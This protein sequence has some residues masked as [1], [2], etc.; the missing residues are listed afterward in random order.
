MPTTV[1]TT[2]YGAA[3]YN[4]LRRAV[5]EAKAGDPLQLVTVVVPSE[6]IGVAARRA[7]AR[8]DH[9]H[10]AGIAAISIMTL[11]RVAETRSARALLAEGRRPLTGP[12]L[13]DAVR[14]RLT[15]DPGPFE[16]VADHIGTVR[17]LADA[18]RTLKPYRDDVLDALGD[19]EVVAATVAVHRAL[20]ADL[21]TSTYDET[22]LLRRAAEHGGGDEP[23]VVLLPQDLDPPE[24]AL[25]E[26][27]ST[28]VDLRILLGITGHDDADAGPLAVARA[29][30]HDVHPDGEA[31]PTA[32]RVLHAS[33]PDDEVRA[34]VRRV[35][36]DLATHKGHRIAVLHASSDPYARLLH[37]HLARADI[38]FFGRGIRPAVESAYGR[39]VMRLL[40]LP[41]HD[42]ART[43]VLAVVA[44]GPVR[45]GDRH[46][47]S[48]AWE[49]V[50]RAA[51][52][53]R[54]AAWSRLETFARHTRAKAANERQ[55]EGARDWL[56]ARHERDSETADDLRAFVEGLQ[57]SLAAIDAAT[58]WADATSAVRRL[59]ELLADD[60]PPEDATAARRVDATLTAAATGTTPPSRRRVVELLE[61][62]LDAVLDRVGTIGIGV[63][64]GP[65][66]EGVGDDVDRVYI[67]GAAEGLLPPR[68]A[69][70]PLLPDR[71]RERT[72]GAL[73]TTR[74][75]TARQHRHV[76]AA[77]AAAPREGRTMSFPRGDLRRGGERVPSRWL[78][79]TLRVLGRDRGLQ[80]TKWRE[81][82]RRLESSSSYPAA[83]LAAH[84][85]ASAQ[86][87]RQV[88]A[89]AGTLEGD[90]TI[91]RAHRLRR[92]R[93]SDQFT[94]YD[95]NLVGE[96][97]P[98]PTASDRLSP[99]ALEEWVRCPHAYF[100]FRLLGV[101]P[102]E[103]PEE[104][105]QISAMERGFVLHDVWDKLV[106]AA[107]D[108]GWAP[109]PGEPWPPRA[110][111]RIE[112]LAESAFAEV[113]ERGVTG[114]RL[115]W[116]QDQ[117]TLMRDLTTWLTKDDERRLRLDEAVPIGAEYAFG[118]GATPAIG[119]ALG[120][121]RELRLRGKI[122]RVDRRRDGGLAVTDYKTGRAD[123]YKT[124]TPEDPTDHGQRLQLPVYALAAREQ[125][126]E[127]PV[128]SEYWFTSLKGGFTP[129]GYD[130][131]D[132]VLDETRRV[133]RVIVDS[134]RDGV[135]LARPPKS[136]FWGCAWCAPD[137]LSTEHVREVWG[138]KQSG[139]EQLRVMLG[140]G[141]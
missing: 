118:E 132:D 51:G 28:T 100:Q 37:E 97:V 111:D 108:E 24:V 48:S 62:E 5:H 40:A 99:T 15:N 33:D 114:A 26:A 79:P 93:A 23:V 66:S 44:G 140:E 74:E 32:A 123:S 21:R 60:L 87:W 53:T 107:L 68:T 14:R 29:L 113:V 110:A 43:E 55:R 77:L 13:A 12:A 56:I 105:V 121:G 92:G 39:T 54:G 102:V 82:G 141:S 91:A 125:Y 90:E 86:E 89:V 63:H 137:G 127:G 101:G 75:R 120:D 52:V 46:A 27:L 19:D 41:E 34:V 84:T 136:S 138:R 6:R 2:P 25:L 3:A 59:L 22:D 83:L 106:N 71:A 88:A 133:L 109:G 9:E 103:E 112:A 130:V 81:I 128:H 1:T 96:D 95:G 126:G 80:A 76:L 17:A 4:A 129:V 65:V 73:P 30:G 35:V 119:I 139:A 18:H 36:D 131:T 38:T 85:P 134:I 20:E 10:P 8:G 78:L 116:E 16:P 67:L 72:N 94:L 70:D 69:D 42:F 122:D 31:V 135:F 117:R 47:P 50:S 98:D 7:L 49:R 58:T 124:I 11:R 61:L 45:H 104:V 115:L 57:S 64:V